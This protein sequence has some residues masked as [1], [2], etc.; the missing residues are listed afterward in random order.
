LLLCT[1]GLSEMVDDRLIARILHERD[2]PRNAA[3]ALLDEAL[4]QGGKDNVTVIVA[5]Y[6]IPGPG[7]SSAQDSSEH[8]PREKGLE[9]T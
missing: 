8:E 2:Q 4:E 1:D 6:E 3:Q 9:T 7:I 5:R